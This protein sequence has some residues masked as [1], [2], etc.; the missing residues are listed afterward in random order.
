MDNAAAS[1]RED[2]GRSE[3]RSLQ[4][5]QRERAAQRLV[6]SSWGRSGLDLPR[7]PMFLCDNRLS[8]SSFRKSPPVLYEFVLDRR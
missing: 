5:G 6:V 1:C 2:V 7:K 8:N 3:E 4:L